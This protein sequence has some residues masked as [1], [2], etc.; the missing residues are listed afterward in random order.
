[1]TTA[2][3]NRHARSQR[4]LAAR[5]EW[6]KLRSVRSTTWTAISV[7]VSSIALSAIASAGTAA[8]WAHDSAAEKASFDPTN[9]S[10]PG[11][12]FGILGIGVVGALSI[13][14][15]YSSGT[16]ATT[17][18]AVPD[19]WALVRAKA[20]VLG[21]AAFVLS[22]ATTLTAF[23][24][25]QALLATKAPHQSLADGNALQAVFLSGLGLTF[26]ALFAHGLGY[27]V[28]HTA[29]AIAAFVGLLLALPLIVLAF[30][31][32]FQNAVDQ[33]LPMDIMSSS[34]STTVREAHTLSPWAGALVLGG[35]AALGL[36]LG[37]R[38]FA[39]RD[40]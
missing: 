6:I 25:G 28:R 15:E 38:R 22:E 12:I 10:L 9:A 7:V 27:L 13:C 26:L 20:M 5:A 31:T 19:R 29:G 21:I 4:T 1:M 36:A 14:S 18:A 23:L 32:S 30:G 40:A 24:C 37:G 2:I 34:V 3:L 33:F 17:L 16:M 11:L 8:G 35:Y 39:R